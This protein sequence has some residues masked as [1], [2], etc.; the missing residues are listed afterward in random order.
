MRG[1]PSN[2]RSTHTH[3][4]YLGTAPEHL[5]AKGECGAYAINKDCSLGNPSASSIFEPT[6]RRRFH[7]RVCWS[8]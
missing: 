8:G 1:R 5:R 2:L 6:L 4:H 3:L 7:A